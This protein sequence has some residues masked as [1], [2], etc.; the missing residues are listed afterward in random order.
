[1][2]YPYTSEAEL[3][4]KAQTRKSCDQL[5]CRQFTVKIIEIVALACDSSIGKNQKDSAHIHNYRLNS[6]TNKKAT[7]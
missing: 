5:I 7:S 1:M 2:A 6:K 4:I 3:F